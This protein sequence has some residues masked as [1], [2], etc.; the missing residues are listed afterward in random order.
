VSLRAFEEFWK[1]DSVFQNLKI[2]S[3]SKDICDECSIFR[4]K[5]SSMSDKDFTSFGEEIKAEHDLYV[6]CY[7]AM[8]DEYEK[9][10]RRCKELSDPDRPVVLS[11]DYAQNVEI[12]HDPLQPQKFYFTSLLKAYQFGV[13]DEE[14]DFHTQY[15]YSE[16]ISGKGADEVA[17]MLL[18]YLVNEMKRKS[19]HLILWADNCPGQNKN[20]TLYQ[21]LS[22][23]VETNM[24]D[25][26]EL[27]FQVKGHT[28]NSVD[29]GFGVTKR[30]YVASAV[31]S[32]DCLKRVIESSVHHKKTLK[33]KA[34]I[35][36]RKGFFLNITDYFLNHLYVKC[37]GILNYHGFKV[38]KSDA[39]KLI[40]FTAA[41]SFNTIAFNIRMK[42]RVIGVLAP[43]QIKGVNLEKVVTFYKEVRKFIPI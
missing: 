30:L 3:P 39:S 35:I 6:R 24:F 27:K 29:R 37:K 38:E 19:P 1:N 10:I 13:V 36:D 25:T 17:S 18:H 26:V 11:F 41:D 33:M 4:T 40:C 31:Y 12:P 14:V 2:R 20:S 15:I 7:R 21:F 32:M 34:I 9:D 8:R 23:L 28:R 43:K 5:I 16:Y 22:G 42:E